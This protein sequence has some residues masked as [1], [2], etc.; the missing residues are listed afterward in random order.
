[1]MHCGLS[2][3]IKCMV[4]CI[5]CAVGEDHFFVK[6]ITYIGIVSCNKFVNLDTVFI[7]FVGVSIS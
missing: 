4:A 2:V 6:V 7:F 5:F 3:C 1:M